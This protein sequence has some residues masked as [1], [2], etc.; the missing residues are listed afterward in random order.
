MQTAKTASLLAAAT[1]AVFLLLLTVVLMYGV[2]QQYFELVH[3]PEKY[4]EALLEHS[5]ALNIIF[6][7]DNIFIILYTCAA[8]F[9]IKAVSGNAPSFVS[10][11]VYILIAAVGLLDFLENFHIYTL[12]QQAKSGI[13]INA[14]DIQWQS[15]ESMMKWHLAYFAFFMLGFLMPAKRFAE[16]LLKYSLLFWFVPTGVLV[17]AAVDTQYAGLFLL[18]RYLNLFSGFVLIGFIMRKINFSLPNGNQ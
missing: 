17:Y 18:L 8:F 14:Q 16:K 12:M 6:I 10:L 1:A 5:K 2:S 11:S 3:S 13:A 4:T 7:F 15:A 9:T